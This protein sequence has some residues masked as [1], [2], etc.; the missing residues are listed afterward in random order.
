MFEL[1]KL[2]ESYATKLLKLRGNIIEFMVWV[3]LL[4]FC[5]NYLG[6]H[7]AEKTSILSWVTIMYEKVS[8]FVWNLLYGDG[9]ERKGQID[10]ARTYSDIMW[11]V[12]EMHCDSIVSK[13]TIQKRLDE[14]KALSPTQFGLLKDS[15]KLFISSQYMNIKRIKF[16]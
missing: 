13:Q 11:Q 3:I 2:Q 7:P 15:Y 4:W 10:L 1:E 5:I 9:I 8:I 14:L 12:D 6:T 16:Q